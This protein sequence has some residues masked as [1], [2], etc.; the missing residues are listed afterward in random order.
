MNRD[1][2]AKYPYISAILNHESGETEQIG[3]VLL[4]YSEAKGKTLG[5]LTLRVEGDGRRASAEQIALTEAV[6]DDPTVR[7]MLDDFYERVAT[8]P[9]LQKQGEPR[10]FPASRLKETRGTV[11][12]DPRRARRA[13]R[14][15]LDQWA[16]S[17][18]AAAFNTLLNRRAA[19]LPGMRL[20][21]C[22][23]FRLRDRLPD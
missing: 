10:Y 7:S 8:D 3:D 18:H 2:A 9:L 22:H 21:P 5:V 4:A 12:W 15:R 20:L 19:I 6:P 16:H 1:I 17:S 11:T 13:T 14:R 23:R